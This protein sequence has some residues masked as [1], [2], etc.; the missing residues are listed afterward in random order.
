MTETTSKAHSRVAIRKIP[1]PV[2]PDLSSEMSFGIK[3]KAQ[4]KDE[5]PYEFDSS[6][7]DS[8]LLDPGIV[9]RKVAS[10]KKST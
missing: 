10:G 4:S 5:I 2:K 6:K 3:T 7:V 9:E 8:A 1:P